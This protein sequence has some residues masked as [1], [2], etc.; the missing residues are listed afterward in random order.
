MRGEVYREYDPIAAELLPDGRHYDPLDQQCWHIALH[1]SAGYI[2]GSSRYRVIEN[3]FEELSVS[4]SALAFSQEYGPSLKTAVERHIQ[5]AALSDIQYGEA[6]MWALRAQARCS[7]AAVTIAL[8]TF[9][10]AKALGGGSGITT[11]TTRHGSSTI[12]QRLGGSTF[13]GLPP[14]YEPK[15]GCVIQVVHFDSVNLNTRYRS[16]MRR[17]EEE[18][19]NCDVICAATPGASNELRSHFQAPVDLLQLSKHMHLANCSRLCSWNTRELLDPGNPT[20]SHS[21]ELCR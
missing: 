12:L 14:Y 3:G 8:M 4:G 17:A 13:P 15:Y 16:R 7:T 20:E 21:A 18:L 5:R 11:A 19:V 6:G 10:L 9:A 2:L 1:T